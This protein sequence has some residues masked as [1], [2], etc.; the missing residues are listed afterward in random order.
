MTGEF[1][2]FRSTVT[3]HLDI[4]LQLIDVKLSD[5][6]ISRF[7]TVET[8]I[9]NRKEFFEISVNGRMD[10]LDGNVDE[11]NDKVNNLYDRIQKVDEKVGQLEM[12]IDS[13]HAIVINRLGVIGG[14]LGSFVKYQTLL[15]LLLNRKC[16]FS[17][18]PPTIVIRQSNVLKRQQT[19]IANKS[20]N[21]TKWLT[22]LKQTY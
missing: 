3:E 17:T 22:G 15:T 2:N 20:F 9:L 8:N 21:F 12:K 13:N 7:T 11:L 16:K 5:A 14:Q 4:K 1:A 6:V 18:K 19:D 10:C